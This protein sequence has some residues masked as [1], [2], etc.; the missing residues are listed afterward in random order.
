[1]KPSIVV[2]AFLAALLGGCASPK[3]VQEVKAAQGQ[4]VTRVYPAAP[5]RVHAAVLAAA[6]AKGLEVVED[7][8]AKG[9]VILSHGT[10]ALSWG[11]KIAVFL[12]PSGTN[13]TQVEVVSKAVME[14]L[15]FPPDWPKIMLDQIGAELQQAK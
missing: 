2:I 4:G 11:E 13:G 12:T 3:T 9:Q 7:D 1:M 14:T 8:P 6:K 10:T 5:D 15:N